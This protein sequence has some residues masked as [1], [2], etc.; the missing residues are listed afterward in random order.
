M[1]GLLLL[2]ANLR[3]AIT[4]V[5]PLLGD[6]R[7]ATD[8]SA[9]IAGLL[10][11][12]P[13]LAFA[14]ISPL[15]PLIARRYGI[16]RTLLGAMVLLAVGMLIRSAGPI[17]AIF[18][19]TALLGSAIAVGN[20]LLPGLVK[21]DFPDRPGLLTGLYSTTMAATAGVAAG[22]S[23]LLAHDAGLGWRGALAI[24]T[25]LV[26]VTVVLWAPYALR[27]KHV[28]PAVGGAREALRLRRS[29]LA[30]QVTLYMGLQSLIFYSLITWLPTLL[31]DEG[32]SAT[33]AGWMV[34]VMQLTSLVGTI[35]APVLAD[36]RPSQRGLVVASALLSLT[37]IAG[38][39]TLGA[40][41]PFV[42]VIPLGLGTGGLFGLALIFLVLRA[43]DARSAG[44]LSGMAQSIGYLM[45]AMGPIG[46]GALHD[47]TGNWHAAM[48]A[49]ALVTVVTL[50]AGLGAARDARV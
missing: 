7:A 5:G 31:Q 6:V 41:A 46:L 45:A 17:A 13:L 14:G 20:V 19:G 12:L 50:V 39:W 11:T 25:V 40:D 28:P 37:G 9:A 10:T 33:A 26:A 16:E 43:S 22:V 21:Q 8:M 42:W 32:M 18:A 2:A 38:L 1:A 27:V 49:L 4:G 15:A 30:W 34:G 36:R 44:A 48:V 24:W 47:A 23:V 3:P 35:G 29:R